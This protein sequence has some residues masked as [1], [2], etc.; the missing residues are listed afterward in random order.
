MSDFDPKSITQWNKSD[1][2]AVFFKYSAP[3]HPCYGY[4]DKYLFVAFL[5]QIEIFIFL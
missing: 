1:A 4:P 2:L 3:I 5:L